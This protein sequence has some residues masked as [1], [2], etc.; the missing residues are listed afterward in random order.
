MLISTPAGIPPKTFLEKVKH[1][2]S[3]IPSLLT[4]VGQ[5]YV[6]LIMEQNSK[7]KKSLMNQCLL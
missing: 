2:L 7:D 1:S 3:D 4:R 6:N 5:V